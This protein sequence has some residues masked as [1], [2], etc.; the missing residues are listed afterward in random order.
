[1]VSTIKALLEEEE[2]R[3]SIEEIFE[4]I[5]SFEEI[6]KYYEN[7]NKSV[8][9]YNESNRSQSNKKTEIS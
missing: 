9:Y 3:P 1:M 6:R 4:K 7:P 5:P 8:D 2:F